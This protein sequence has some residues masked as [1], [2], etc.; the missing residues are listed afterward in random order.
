MK[1][2][3]VATLAAVS[4]ACIAAALAACAPE[5]GPEGGPEGIKNFSQSFSDGR[6]VFEW[7]GD[8]AADVWRADSADGEY[9]KVAT[10]TN[11]W[12][13]EDYTAWY[14][15]KMNVGGEQFATEPYCYYN[16]FGDNVYVY[17]GQDSQQAIQRNIDEV[18]ASLVSNEFSLER[19]AFIFMPGEYPE[20][21]AK[22]GYYTSFYGAGFSPEEVTLGGFSVEQRPD[23]DS[24]LTNFWRSAENFSVTDDAQWSVSQ[25]TSLRRMNFGG[26]LSLDSGG[27]SSGGYIG[28]SVIA[29]NI[30]NSTQQQWFTRNS[31]F[32]EWT[33]TDI[34]MVF[35][36]V[37]GKIRGEWP[38][39]R[40]T[41]LE[42][43]ETMREKPFITFDSRQ[44]FG[45]FVPEMRYNSKGA[46][47][48]EDGGTKGYF[49]SLEDFYIANAETDT[50]QTI[51]DALAEGKH[52]LLTPGIYVLE[53][54]LYISMG[55]TV[56][57]GMG[58]ATL[59]TAPSNTE[60]CVQVGNVPGVSIS[61]V[62]LD[63]GS[64]TDMLMRVGEDVHDNAGGD[65]VILSDLFFR[66]G[67][68]RFPEGDG[69]APRTVSVD[70][71]LEINSDNVIGDNFWVWRA[72]HSYGVGWK[73]ARVSNYGKHGV[74]VNGDNVRCYGLMVEHFGE[75]QTYWKGENGFVCFYQSE[76]PYD[77]TDQQEWMD[78][79]KYGYASYK[80]DE[81]VNTHT[82]YGI[83]VYFV[84]NVYNV[85]LDNAI[86]VPEKSGITM[87]HM[88]IANFKPSN[89]PS[90]RTLGINSIINGCGKSVLTGGAKQPFTSFMDGKY[91]E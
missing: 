80:V 49:I 29:G 55:E 61:G 21:T 25:A 24:C 70:T 86:E 9:E 68:G 79:D 1:K 42:T 48:K 7:E 4:A 83:G 76:T 69:L 71:A 90:G 38:F 33:K 91:T 6:L 62:L 60:G 57:L 16:I 88:A 11:R 59:Q 47:W 40:N 12:S 58:L 27:Y 32:T 65:P 39:V 82:A 63:A 36:G 31:Q 34:N 52:L 44:G 56:V 51:N 35:S 22:I 85:Q 50:A 30:N 13:T 89:S 46:S 14:V 73:G 78:G 66:I 54:P 26:N 18:Y 28:D 15:L 67:G 20:V 77:P 74:V 87:I 3:I 10:A 5:G 17:D 45:V 2:F 37:E 19:K 41:V 81:S 53:E 23:M 64:Q 72:D 75:Y 8:R 84:C 43:T